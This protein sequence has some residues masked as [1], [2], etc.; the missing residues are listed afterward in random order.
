MRKHYIVTRSKHKA[1][2]E[3]NQKQ[4]EREKGLVKFSL[5]MDVNRANCIY[6]WTL[7]SAYTP[8]EQQ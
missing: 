3:I 6:N 4:T 2:T 1:G 7:M 8:A 5:G